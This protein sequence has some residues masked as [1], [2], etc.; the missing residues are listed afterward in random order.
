MA[1]GYTHAVADGTLTDPRKFILRCARAMGAC[2]MQR[3]DPMDDPPKPQEP[4]DFYRKSLEEARA[5]RDR[6]RGMSEREIAEAAKASND[7]SRLS[8]A[9]AI[10]HTCEQKSR[11]QAM[12]A[13]VRAW[14]PPTSEHVGLRDFMVEQLESSIQFDCGYERPES[15]VLLPSAFQSGACCRRKRR[16]RG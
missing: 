8:R 9:E 11:Y 6:L 7:R 16:R 4:A 14:V 12:L 5:R 15:K 10:A 3:E 2:I 1:T 13:A